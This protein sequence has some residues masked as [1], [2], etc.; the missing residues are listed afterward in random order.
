LHDA[1]QV[2]EKSRASPLIMVLHDVLRNIEQ[3]LPP[4]KH[5]IE[6]SEASMAQVPF[7]TQTPPMV[8]AP[9]MAQAP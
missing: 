9:P 2:I 5:Y 6:A 7:M 4:L 1:T 8:Q 3:M